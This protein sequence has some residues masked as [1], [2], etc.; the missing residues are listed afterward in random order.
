MIPEQAGVRYMM[1]WT[2]FVERLKNG[3]H[4]TLLSYCKS[5]QVNSIAFRRWLYV[6]RLSVI[7]VKTHISEETGMQ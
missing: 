5:M 4:I 3:E 1:V 7:D 6:N 2:S